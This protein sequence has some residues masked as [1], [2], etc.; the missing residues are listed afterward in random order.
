MVSPLLWVVLLGIIGGAVNGYL[1]DQVAWKPR[2][3]DTAGRPGWDFGIFGNM[4]LGGVAALIS[5]LAG[6][7]GLPLRAQY[8][9]ALVSGIGFGNVFASIK[10]R[11][12]LIEQ[13]RHL[14]EG[15]HRLMLSEAG[16]EELD[17]TVREEMKDIID[18]G[19]HRRSSLP[20][21]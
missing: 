17:K 14:E 4:A 6:P 7:E 12:V 13:R 2:S 21:A 10:Q 1:V 18:E 19:G 9:L 20:K 3:V 11:G 16:R 15:E 8:G 5:Y